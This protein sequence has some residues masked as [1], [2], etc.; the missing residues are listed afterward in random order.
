MD[1][2]FGRQIAEGHVYA[3][4]VSGGELGGFI[5]FC[6]ENGYMVLE[7]VAV[8]PDHAGQGIGRALIGFCEDRARLSGH[9]GVRLYTNEAMTEPQVLY[10]RLGYVESARRIEDGFRRIH[11]EKSFVR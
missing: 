1:A 8:H 4:V 9:S 2:D 6:P 11:Y 3:A 10:A 7:T 5:V